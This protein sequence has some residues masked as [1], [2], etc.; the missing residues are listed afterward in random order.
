MQTI[1]FGSQSSERVLNKI[2]QKGS[3]IT[4]RKI[5]LPNLEYKGEV[6]KS[7]KSIEN[8]LIEQAKLI[9]GASQELS[10]FFTDSPKRKCAHILK[11]NRKISKGSSL[12]KSNNLQTISHVE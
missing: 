6:K 8:A 2:K 3:P 4:N 5:I 11:I 12:P 9:S 10:Y 1:N 7:L